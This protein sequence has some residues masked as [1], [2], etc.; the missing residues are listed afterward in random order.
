MF[1]LQSVFTQGTKNILKSRIKALPPPFP[2]LIL[3]LLERHLAGGKVLSLRPGPADPMQVL[4][5]AV[6][7]LAGSRAAL[8]AGLRAQL[9]QAVPPSF[10]LADAVLA[11]FDKADQ[12]AALSDPGDL[13]A[14]V[15]VALTPD[16]DDITDFLFDQMGK[17][18]GEGRENFAIVP[19]MMDILSPD[20]D[21]AELAHYEQQLRRTSRQVLRYPG[22][23]LPFVAAN[24]RRPTMLETVVDA[25]EHQGFV[26][27]K[28]YPS[29]GYPVNDPGL[30]G[31]YEYC[32]GNHVPLTMHCSTEGFYEEKNFIAYSDPNPWREILRTYANLRICFGHFGGE[33]F[34]LHTPDNTEAQWNAAILDMMR[35]AT[36]GS[37]V[38]ADLSY[39][40]GGMGPAWAATG[41]F[42]TLNALLAEP[43]LRAQI[44]WG[45]DFFLVRQRITEE[46]YWQYFR[47]RIT[48]A[49]A[50]DAITRDNPRRFLGCQGGSGVQPPTMR[51][52]LRFLTQ[53]QASSGPSRQLPAAAWTGL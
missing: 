10:S 44:L 30:A 39:N 46:H 37:R 5:A 51:N 34:F 2:D 7:E 4:A 28:L 42:D 49:A 17:A 8:P 14:F 13:A 40:T 41:Y 33:T 20:P 23:V 32:D 38:F 52:Y 21:A 1:N 24:P 31:L 27:V 45:T 48:D 11:L 50:F 25:L 53:C 35:D 29:L 26:G 6:E 22:R 18:F 16:M 19:L 12:D 47:K 15:N 36:I 9:L 43:A 3:W